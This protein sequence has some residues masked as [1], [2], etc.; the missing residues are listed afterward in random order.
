MNLI[1]DGVEWVKDVDSLMSQADPLLC[2]N[3]VKIKNCRCDRRRR[4][5]IS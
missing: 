2:M 5:R 3:T 4:S 1:D